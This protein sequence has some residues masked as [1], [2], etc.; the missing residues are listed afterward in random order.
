MSSAS[1]PPTCCRNGA[2]AT[3]ARSP[4]AKWW[5]S[6]TGSSSAAPRRWRTGAP[7]CFRR[8]SGLAC[9]GRWSTP[10]RCSCSTG[11]AARRNPAT[12][13]SSDAE[14]S[15]FLA[16]VDA[17][18][19]FQTG[20]NGRTPRLAHALR[21]LLLTGQRRGELALARWQDVTLTGKAPAWRIPAEHSKPAPRMRC[22]SPLPQSRSFKRCR[23]TRTAAPTSS[24]ATTARRRDPKLHHPQRRA[25]REALSGDRRAPFT[26]HD[27]RTNM[28]HRLGAAQGAA[29]HRRANLES[30]AAGDA[31]GLRPARAARGHAGGAR[32]VGCAPGEA[33]SRAGD[34]SR[35]V[36]ALDRELDARSA[37]RWTSGRGCTRICAAIDNGVAR[38]ST[39]LRAAGGRRSDPRCADR[40]RDRSTPRCKRGR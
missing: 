12:G 4:R 8:C 19:R 18:M 38:S 37:G 21:L 11:R 34:L 9:I 27:L 22:R 28:P 16:N 20:G 7:G 23:S 25:Q 10:P 30:Q 31:R 2:P 6:S 33:V 29:R 15:A 24:R 26:A 39:R 32:E 14:L 3:R 5:S 17:V 40:G 1:W 13:R 36:R 35:A